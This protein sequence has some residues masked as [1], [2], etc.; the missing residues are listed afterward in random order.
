MRVLFASTYATGHFAPLIP[1]AQAC[2][3]A[4]HDVLVAGPPAVE[5]LAHRA[6]LAHQPVAVADPQ[7][8]GPRAPDDV[9]P[10][11]WS[12][13]IT[14]STPPSAAIAPPST[15]WPM[16]PSACSP[17]RRRAQRATSR[18]PS[19]ASRARSRTRTSGTPWASAATS[20]GYAKIRSKPATAVAGSGSW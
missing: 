9:R 15:C 7:A 11:R 10:G 16:L 17:K 4:G 2:R 6:G 18:A 12:A 5:E 1:F 8:T 3:D 20:E 13:P 19:R 14:S